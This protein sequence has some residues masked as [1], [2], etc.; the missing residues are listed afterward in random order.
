[1]PGSMVTGHSAH[2][3]VIH[4]ADVELDVKRCSVFG[5]GSVMKVRGLARYKG[6]AKE[7]D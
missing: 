6:P 2:G 7:P 3:T 5:D 4:V 1:M